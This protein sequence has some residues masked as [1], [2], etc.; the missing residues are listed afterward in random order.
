MGNSTIQGLGIRI[1]NNRLHIKRDDLIPLS[2]GGNKARK[3]ILF[4]EDIVKTNS[5][6]VVTYGSSSSNHCRIIS[7][8]ATS[9]GM[10]CY[11]VSPIESNSSTNNSKI[12]GLFGAK[13]I[14]CPVSAVRETI[15]NTVDKLKSKGFRPT[16]SRRWTWGYRN[17]GLCGCL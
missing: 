1:N 17:P 15:K 11:I 16:L 2:F 6:C 9:K 8:L 5:D 4:F 7:N 13:I 10:P 12:V 3:A 14:K